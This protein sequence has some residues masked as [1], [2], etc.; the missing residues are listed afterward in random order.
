M[1][2][3]KQIAANRRNA[4]RSTGPRTQSGKSRSRAN[5]LRHGLLS[6][7]LKD[8][9]LA[10]ETEELAIRIAR[11]H[12]KPDHAIEARTIAEAEV[13]I[14]RIRAIR[15]NLFDAIAIDE[16]A[17]TGQQSLH[18]PVRATRRSGRQQ[19]EPSNPNQAYL[20]AIPE[21]FKLDR[22]EQRAIWRRRHALR[23]LCQ[24]DS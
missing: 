10:A 23:Q 13:T 15:A 2:S 1:S 14:L 20:R 4:N 11:E 8:F 17:C 9:A 6:N 19:V 5:A 7:A 12:G 18:H 21:L 24:R 3:K 16:P 22:Y